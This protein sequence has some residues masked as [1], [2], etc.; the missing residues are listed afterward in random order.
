MVNAVVTH[1]NRDS[2]GGFR[3]NASSIC[4]TCGANLYRQFSYVQAPPLLAFDIAGCGSGHT[5]ED[6]LSIGVDNQIWTY[7]LRGVIYHGHEHFTARIITADG[8]VWYHDGMETGSHVRWEGDSTATV[9][10]MNICRSQ[11]AIVAIYALRVP[12]RI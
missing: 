8:T 5:I 1:E 2:N 4:T 10:D 12:R 7:A 9:A 11:C 6:E 3:V